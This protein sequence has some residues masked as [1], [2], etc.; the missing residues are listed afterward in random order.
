[1]AR[2]RF[3]LEQFVA[4][5]FGV[6][7]QARTTGAVA[8]LAL[9]GAGIMRHEPVRELLTDGRLRANFPDFLRVCG[10]TS[11]PFYDW[12]ASSPLNRDGKEHQRWRSLMSR[13]FT[14][15]SVERLRPFLRAA[16]HELIDAFAARGSCEFVGEFADAYPSLGLCELIGVPKEDRARFRGWANTIG[17]GF[18]PL[19]GQYV[20]QVDAALTQLLAYTGELA[21]ARRAAPRDDLVTRIAQAADEDGWTDFEVRGAIAGLVFAGHETTKNQLGWMVALLADRPD[22]WEAVAEGSLAPADVVEEVLRHRGAVTGV[23]RTVVEPVAVDGERLEPGEQ[24]FLSVWSANH[25]ERA[26][27]RPASL[28]PGTNADPPHLAFGHGAHYCLGAALA[29]AELQEGLAALTARLGCPTVA[30]D[31]QWKPPLGITGPER[32]PITFVA[33]AARQTARA[34]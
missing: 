1:M 16:A 6:L 25:D 12:M 22:V 29:R 7:R 17:L 26:Y 21:A 3:D 14:P 8:D 11:G 19:V 5:P 10:V 27:P 9:G 34:T 28:E 23:G 18:S 2:F 31:A 20:T 32:L 24:L 4:D 33:R 30:A 15:R 13:T